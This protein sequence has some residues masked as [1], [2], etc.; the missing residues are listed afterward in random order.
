MY[1]HICV[2]ELPMN[3]EPLTSWD[4]QVIRENSN[5]GTTT[6]RWCWKHEYI[7]LCHSCPQRAQG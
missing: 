5:S 3:C 6:S 2:C 4:A 1:I 7:E